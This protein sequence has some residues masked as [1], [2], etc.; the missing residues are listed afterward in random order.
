[1]ECNIFMELQLQQDWKRIYSALIGDREIE[2][3]GN[4][5]GVLKG[6]IIHIR[7]L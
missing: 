2:K 5:A 6:D 4:F 7:F 3:A 1:M